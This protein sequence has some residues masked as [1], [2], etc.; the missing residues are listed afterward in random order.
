MGRNKNRPF[1]KFHMPALALLL[2][3]F[4]L[5]PIC[6]GSVE[7][8]PAKVGIGAFFGGARL[9][10]TGKVPQGA[11][12]VIEVVGRS[13]EQD[14]MR[15][16][17]RWD[18]WMNVGEVDVFGAP[19]LYYVLSSSPQLISTANAN[20]PWGYSALRKE[21][22]FR[23]DKENLEAGKLF[24]EFIKLKESQGLYGVFPDAVTLSSAPSGTESLVHAVISVP[25]RITP[26]DYQICLL[27]VKGEQSAS[28][29]CVPFHVTLVGLPAFLSSLA[30]S[31]AVLYG[32][33]AVAIAVM[34]GFLS[35][36]LFKRRK[37][38]GS[39]QKDQC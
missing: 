4:L 15:K 32:L 20:L 31:H 26:G 35:G 18:I 13:A 3:V 21:I 7:V 19:R 39:Q 24:E 34:A 28:T 30:H 10:V 9:T 22:S 11:Q 12:A 25:T 8:A 16:G 5:P 14:L 27:A 23:S 17:R 38:L 29:S 6:A 1:L 36:L 37:I 2:A 33:L